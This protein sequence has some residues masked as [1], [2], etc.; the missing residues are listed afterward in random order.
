MFEKEQDTTQC[1]GEEAAAATEET[2]RKERRNTYT[3]GE[4]KLSLI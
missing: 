2:V 4:I 3:H 1:P